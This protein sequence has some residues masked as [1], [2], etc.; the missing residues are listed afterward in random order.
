MKSHKVT[1]H[2]DTTK[3]VD[4]NY[5]KSHFIIIE[6]GKAKEKLKQEVEKNPLTIRNHKAKEVEEINFQRISQ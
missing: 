6:A 2:S 3:L 5:E 4:I 1:K